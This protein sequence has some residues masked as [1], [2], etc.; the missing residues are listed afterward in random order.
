MWFLCLRSELC[1]TQVDYY[2]K[3]RDRH[4]IYIALMIDESS[5][6]VDHRGGIVLTG[7]N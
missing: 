6:S 7:E 2:V 3:E 1:Y 4:F 5:M